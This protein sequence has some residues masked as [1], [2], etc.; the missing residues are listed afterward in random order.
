MELI[1]ADQMTPMAREKAV[2]ALVVG[3][4][5]IKTI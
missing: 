2:A 3:G 5:H 1:A 4:K